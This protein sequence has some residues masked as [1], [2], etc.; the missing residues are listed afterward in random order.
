MS[1]PDYDYTKAR[2]HCRA[3]GLVFDERL[4]PMCN[5]TFN[6]ALITQ[7]QLEAIMALHITAV[8]HQWQRTNY[9]WYQ[10]IFI[11]LYWLGLGRCI[12][13]GKSTR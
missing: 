10:R 11:A 1:G 6:K 7:E 4:L 12:G 5:D 9:K 3:C 13:Y 8:V 2:E